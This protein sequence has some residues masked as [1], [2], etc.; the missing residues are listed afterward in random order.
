MEVEPVI[1]VLLCVLICITGFIGGLLVPRGMKV[2]TITEVV[3]VPGEC[4]NPWKLA[5]EDF[6]G[7]VKDIEKGYEAMSYV[8]KVYYCQQPEHRNLEECK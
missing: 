3:E 1:A 8:S 7:K 6:E 4:D 2:Q 5:M